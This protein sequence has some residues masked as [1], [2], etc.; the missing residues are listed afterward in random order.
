MENRIVSRIIA[1]TV[2][3]VPSIY[4]QYESKSCAAADLQSSLFYLITQS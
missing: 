1:T 4:Q 3:R 2:V